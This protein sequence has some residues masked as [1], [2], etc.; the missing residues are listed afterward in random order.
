[1]NRIRR[2]A[3]DGLDLRGYYDF[4]LPA[5]ASLSEATTTIV[6]S[7][8]DADAITTV[9]ALRTVE[10]RVFNILENCTGNG[11]AYARLL[12]DTLA[13]HEKLWIQWKLGACPNNERVAT[14]DAPAVSKK[15][16][17]GEIVEECVRCVK[18]SV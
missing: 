3:A 6:A 13:R 8:V 9:Q 7:G 12:F 18:N 10:C 4:Q 2:L 17:V 15:R 16:N 14:A 1:M 5:S 11:R